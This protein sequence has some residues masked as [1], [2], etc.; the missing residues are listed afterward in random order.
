MTTSPYRYLL[1]P[2]P[3]RGVSAAT[4]ALVVVDMQQ[5]DADREMGWGKRL[6]EEGKATLAESF[7]DRVEQLVVPT[8]QRLLA[9]CRQARVR[10]IFIRI[11]LADDDLSPLS[12]RYRE[13]G[14]EARS[15]SPEAQILPALSPASGEEILSKTGTSAFTSTGLGELLEARGI[16]TLL[17]AGV[18][19]DA[20]VDLTSRDAADRGYQVVVV[21]DGC[22]AIAGISAHRAALQRFARQGIW[23]LKASQVIADLVTAAGALE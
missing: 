7:F 5:L 9:A 17:V 3:W 15:G 18:N 1:N 21:E 12:R 14:F 22:A 4:A 11:A 16:E 8:I 19:T 20:C 23:V 2:V 6:Q 13:L 10:V